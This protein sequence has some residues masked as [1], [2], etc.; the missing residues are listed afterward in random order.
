MLVFGFTRPRIV[1]RKGRYCNRWG[2]QTASIHHE[3][4]IHWI[5]DYIEQGN[6][7]V[8][9]LPGNDNPADIFKRP[10]GRLSCPSSAHTSTMSLTF[11]NQ[12]QF[13]FCA[14]M[15][16]CGISWF[17]ALG[18]RP[19]ISSLLCVSPVAPSI[20]TTFI[21]ATCTV[22]AWAH[23]GWEAPYGFLPTH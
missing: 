9:Y 22:Y 19:L 17:C 3:T 20:V 15:C 12:F 4:C 13:Q 11:L 21:G 18:G 5:S 1:R 16:L 7:M 14:C 2:T 23:G 6:I 8:S 10:F